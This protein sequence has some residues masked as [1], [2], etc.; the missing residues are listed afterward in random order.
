MNHSCDDCIYAKIVDSVDECYV[1]CMNE[2]FSTSFPEFMGKCK[3]QTKKE[4]KN[5]DI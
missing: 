2:N 4:D 1:V 5:N 3:Y